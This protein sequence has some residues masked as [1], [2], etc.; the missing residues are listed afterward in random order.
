MLRPLKKGAIL[1]YK[2]K[3]GIIMRSI[4]RVL[5]LM[6]M[7]SSFILATTVVTS[8]ANYAVDEIVTTTISGT[9][10]GDQDWVGI[11]PK[12]ASS[13]WE[14]VIRW[15]WAEEGVVT[16][17]KGD[18]PM[19]EGEYEVRLFFHNST[20][21]EDIE[22][23]TEFVVSSYGSAGPYLDDVVIDDH[24]KY[25]V[26]K[27]VGHLDNAPV[28]LFVSYA[29]V[30][31][32]ANDPDYPVRLEGLMKFLASKG[33]CVIGAKKNP[34][35]FP[36]RGVIKIF[37]DAISETLALHPNIDVSK[38]GVIGQSRG[39]GQVFKIMKELKLKNYGGDKSFVIPLDGSFS[40][41]M[42]K[43]DL[44]TFQADTLFIQYGGYIGNIT[45]PRRTL[46]IHKLLSN[47][48][49]KGFVAIHT[50]VGHS[51]EAHKYSY[52]DLNNILA[53]TKLVQSIGAMVAYKFFND[54]HAYDEIF[55]ENE[56][57]QTIQ[58]IID[59]PLK[60]IGGYSF[61]CD[62][63]EENDENFYDLKFNYCTEYLN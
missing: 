5:F 16:L 3:K 57:S 56:T 7:I 63:S 20:S 48:I 12:G 49:N 2:I 62:G 50:N 51:W 60:E 40:H 24:E 55:N 11:Y 1:A 19:P 59:V 4:Q 45:D 61:D 8:K 35:L 34:S 39:G 58:N 15:N 30:L 31:G 10:S 54:P 46:S 6:L 17:S 41:E 26:Y 25:V 38:L 13:A 32:E 28:V 27:P 36:S 44:G 42:S 43:D 9:L 23:K 37:E 21:D 18:N 53:K 29:T 22:A 14:N 47:N 52:G 33:I